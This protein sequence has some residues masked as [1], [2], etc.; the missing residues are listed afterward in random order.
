MPLESPGTSS[1]GCSNK[2]QS[3]TPGTNIGTEMVPQGGILTKK[4]GFGPGYKFLKDGCIEHY[5]KLH[6]LLVIL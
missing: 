1:E 4:H 6:I 3:P 5:L 2:L